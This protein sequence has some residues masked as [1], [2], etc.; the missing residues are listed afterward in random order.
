MGQTKDRQFEKAF[1]RPVSLIKSR[2]LY[3]W[4]A[5]IFESPDDF[6]WLEITLAEHVSF[7]TTLCT[8]QKF[9]VCQ[10]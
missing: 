9:L 1:P 8:V 7:L 2:T 6:I 5:V 4:V 3:F 10:H